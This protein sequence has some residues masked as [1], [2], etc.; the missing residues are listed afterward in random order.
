V[1]TEG[2]DVKPLGVE[3]SKWCNFCRV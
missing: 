2:K 1:E 3:S